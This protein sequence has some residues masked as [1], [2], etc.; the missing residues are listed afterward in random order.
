VYVYMYVAA[1]CFATAALKR[2]LSTGGGAVGGCRAAAG[3]SP[4]PTHTLRCNHNPRRRH[5]RSY[6]THHHTESALRIAAA[7]TLLGERKKGACARGASSGWAAGTKRN[8]DERTRAR[9]GSCV[10]L[11]RLVLCVRRLER[12]RERERERALSQMGGDTMGE[13]EER[14]LGVC[15]NAGGEGG[16]T[17]Q[18][19]QRAPPT[20]K[21][22]PA[23]QSTQ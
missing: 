11:F 20:D 7:A 22:A 8:K 18:M 5:K 13:R 3:L 9:A 6:F 12:E 23:R 4:R 15:I 17:T 21:P 1:L 10:H 2:T 14:F 16:Q 19:L